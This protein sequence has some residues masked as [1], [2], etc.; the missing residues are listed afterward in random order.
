MDF[1][2]TDLLKKKK[3]KKK[4]NE[5][6]RQQNYNLDISPKRIITF[7]IIIAKWNENR[8]GRKISVGIAI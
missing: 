4:K 5:S 8:R 2:M 6:W 1:E 7:D 3:K